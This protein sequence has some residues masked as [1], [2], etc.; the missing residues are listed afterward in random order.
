MEYQT[1][2]IETESRLSVAKFTDAEQ[3]RDTEQA[4]NS[5]SISVS[6]MR[7]SRPEHQIC[8][9]RIKSRAENST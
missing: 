8:S 6:S 9:S 1:A 7:L 5:H 2:E 4:N 3:N